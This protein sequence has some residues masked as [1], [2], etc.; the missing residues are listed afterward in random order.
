MSHNT[1]FI[2][3]AVYRPNKYIKSSSVPGVWA[4]TQVLVWERKK[5]IPKGLYINKQCLIEF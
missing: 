1:Q 4:T 5:Y 2:K 3:H